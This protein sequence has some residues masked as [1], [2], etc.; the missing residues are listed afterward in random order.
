MKNE[1]THLIFVLSAVIL[2][3]VAYF[4]GAYFIAASDMPTWFKF[5]LLR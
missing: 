3:T 5:W 4:I 1:W 2:I